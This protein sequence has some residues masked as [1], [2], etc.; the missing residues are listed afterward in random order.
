MK[1]HGINPSSIPVN[2]NGEVTDLLEHCQRLEQQRK[3]ERLN[4]PP[5]RIIG[6]PSSQD[7]LLGKGHPFQNHAGNK[8]L[9][10]VVAERYREYEKALK[11][12]KKEIAESVIEH[13]KSN[14]GLFL[15]QDGGKWARADHEIV[16]LKVSAAFRTLRLKGGI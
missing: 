4:Y 2:N 1:S 15:K 6:M 13:I 16:V 10:L 12:A 3:H 11:G 5:R 14:G 9:R 8:N 7:V